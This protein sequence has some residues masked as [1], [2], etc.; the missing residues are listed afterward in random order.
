M[1]AESAA[2]S[3]PIALAGAMLGGKHA[4]PGLSR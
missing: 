2:G 1:S 3:C 4:A